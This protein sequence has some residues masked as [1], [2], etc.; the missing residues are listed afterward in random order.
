MRFMKCVL[1]FCLAELVSFEVFACVFQ[2][3]TGQEL[4]PTLIQWHYTVFGIELGALA[5]LKIAEI[6]DFKLKKKK[7]QTDDPLAVE[8]GDGE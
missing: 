8:E 3:V 2:C 5:L 7:P 1:V 6:T 4:S